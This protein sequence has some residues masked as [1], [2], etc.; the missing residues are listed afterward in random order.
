MHGEP[1]I[2]KGKR[3][4]MEEIRRIYIAMRDRIQARLNEFKRVGSEGS[5]KDIFAELVFCILTP[6]S[7]AKSC[8]AAVEAL[9][10]K[11]LLLDGNANRIA[12]ELNEV[13]FKNKKAGYI[14]KARK[15]FTTNGG[16]SIGAKM[17]QFNQNKDARGWLAQNVT[18]MGY[19][20]AS[21]FLRNIG[22]G[23]D[24]AILDRHVL[25]NLRLL[26]VIEEIPSSLSKSRYFEIEKSMKEFAEEINVPMGRLDLVLWYKETGE[27]FK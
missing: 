18:G 7:K 20:E 24:L 1:I 3:N 26:G 8:W 19:K 21:H 13:R 5:E 10:N 9:F 11:N 16:I 2:K 14:V 6:Q 15:L 23:E 17:K 25:K 22:L 27:I 4:T 12:R